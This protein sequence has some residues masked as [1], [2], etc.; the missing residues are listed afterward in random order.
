M[1]QTSINY[2]SVAIFFFSGNVCSNPGK[3][4]HS[5][6]NFHNFSVGAVVHYECDSGYAI[7]DGDA[8]IK[9]VKS[10]EGPDWVGTVPTCASKYTW[11]L[12]IVISKALRWYNNSTLLV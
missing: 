6:M 12:C 9:C 11:C 10:D 4:E 2:H 7:S 5:S 1:W 8:T 3:P